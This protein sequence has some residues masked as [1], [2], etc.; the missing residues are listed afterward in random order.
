MDMG[1]RRA[2]AE[3]WQA[4]AF[5]PVAVMIATRRGIL[6]TLPLA[7]IG[8]RH[9]KRMTR[10]LPCAGSPISLAAAADTTGVNTGNLTNAFTINVL[11][12]MPPIWEWY[13]GIVTGAN[14]AAVPVLGPCS[15]YLNKLKP[16]SFTFPAASGSEYDPGQPKQFRSGDELFFFW[17]VASNQ[18]PVPVVT[19]FL[20]Y[21]ADLPANQSFLAGA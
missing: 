21:D 19:L 1:T 15:V 12:T 14:P 8:I 9:P 13:G 18:T 11:G 16:V 5:S 17:Q 7:V 3:L 10:Y 4:M 20:R 6:G 2:L